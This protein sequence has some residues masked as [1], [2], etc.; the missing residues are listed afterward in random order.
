MQKAMYKTRSVC[1]QAKQIQNSITHGGI[2]DAY[3]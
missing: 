3:C 2:L 1:R